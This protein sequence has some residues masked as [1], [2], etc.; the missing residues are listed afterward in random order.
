MERA[1][2][3]GILTAASL[4]VGGAAA[5]DAVA[6]ARRLERLHVGLHVTVAAGPPVLPRRE[7]PDLVD[8]SGNLRVG[9]AG[10]G[11]RFF[12]RRRVREQLA[13]EI[14]AQFEAFRAT[15]L[16]LDHVNVHCHMQLHPTVGRLVLAIGRDYGMRA[17]RIPAEPAALLF[18]A[19]AGP[20]A[21]A[22]AALHAALS[23]PLRRRARAAGLA[24]NDRLLGIAW[25][26]AMTEAR[27]MR[28]IALL[29]EGLSELYSHP[30]ASRTPRLARA[31]P[32]YRQQE[33]LDALTSPAVRRL[34]ADQGIA[35]GGYGDRA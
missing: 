8:D 10:A 14:C 15:G 7:I 5:A 35:L 24:V 4:M 21:L 12:F 26:G 17:L 2:H 13:R 3:D 25:S 32:H 1:Y 33:E 22:V 23:A 29:P 31:M 34:V 20:G 18:R 11:F 19:G 16:V 27:V 30:A 28:L 9:L 6:R